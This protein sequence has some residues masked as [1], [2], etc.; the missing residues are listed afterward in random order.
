MNIDDLKIGDK[1]EIHCYKHNGHLHRQWDEA[2][3]LDIKDIKIDSNSV[4]KNTLFICMKGEDFDGHDYVYQAE[5]YSRK[6]E[7]FLRHY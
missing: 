4:S 5:N 7:F 2:I 6:P 1:L 3:L